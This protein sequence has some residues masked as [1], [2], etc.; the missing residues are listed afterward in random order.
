MYLVRLTPKQQ[1]KRAFQHPMLDNLRQYNPENDADLIARSVEGD[2]S[3]KQEL[4]ETHL[5]IVAWLVSRYLG[6]WPTT[7]QFLDDMVSEAT[8]AIWEQIETLD[9]IIEGE[10][11]RS[12]MILL[13][14]KRIE[15][16]LN[17]NM[18]IVNAS[19]TTNQRRLRDGKN[20]EAHMAV[21][22]GKHENSLTYVNDDEEVIDAID[23]FEKLYETDSEEIVDLVYQALHCK[24]G[25]YEQDL[26]ERQKERVHE[27]ASI[28]SH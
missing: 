12:K 9:K 22:V 20:M 10:H 25:I 19:L 6:N 23:V 11:L 14:R 3:A 8:M 17:N 27:L 7:A 24:H 16:F 15:Q 2:Q 26:S 28:M 21:D 5:I 13:C 4:F 1:K 18:Y